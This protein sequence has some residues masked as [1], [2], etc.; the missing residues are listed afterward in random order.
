MPVVLPEG[1]TVQQSPLDIAGIR[2][3]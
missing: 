1:S 2:S 3:V